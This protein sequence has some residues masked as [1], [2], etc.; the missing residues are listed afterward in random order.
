MT[1]SEKFD[2]YAK[3]MESQY[4]EAGIRVELDNRAESIPKKV[5]EA[6]LAKKPIMLPDGEKEVESNT[7]ALRTLDGQVKFGVNPD[8]LLNALKE[9]IKNKELKFSL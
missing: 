9:N 7:V 8:A 1:V 3:R 2:E 5:R 4:K 6:Q